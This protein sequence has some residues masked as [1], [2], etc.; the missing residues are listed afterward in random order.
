[1]R[2]PGPSARDQRADGRASLAAAPPAPGP[3][4]ASDFFSRLPPGQSGFPD[5]WRRL[6]DPTLH[7]PFAITAWLLLHGQLG[8]RAF[9]HH[10]QRQLP[11]ISSPCSALCPSPAC[12]A[13]SHADSLTHAFLECPDSAAAVDWL[14]A[15]WGALT[16]R[17]APPRSASVLLADELRFWAVDSPAG[18]APLLALWTRLR[19]SVIGGIWKMRCTRAQGPAHGPSQ[20][21]RAV[22]EAV[23]SLV[24]AIQRDWLRTTTDIRTLDNGSFCTEWWR[25]MDPQLSLAKF[26]ATWAHQG[27]FCVVDDGDAEAVPPRAPALTLRLG[28]DLPIPFPV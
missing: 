21:R 22:Q 25:G 8:C 26:R 17:A 13:A 28:Q 11:F 14:C 16:G 2:P 27:V 15:V 18:D 10:V 9:L 3:V 5:V 23:L 1:V 20:A 24:R 7:R 19:V 4:A 12:S 6:L